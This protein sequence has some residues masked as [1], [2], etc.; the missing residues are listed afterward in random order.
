MVQMRLLLRRLGFFLILIAALVITFALSRFTSSWHYILPVEPGQVAYIAT[1]DHLI[2]DWDQY[3]GLV[4]AQIAD[5]TLRLSAD[6]VQKNPFS[7]TQQHFADFDLRVEA[8]PAE[9]PMNNGYGVVFRVDDKDNNTPTDDSLYRFLISSDGYY[10]VERVIEGDRKWLSAWNPSS[11]VSQGINVT[12]WV[13]VIAEGDRFQFFING[14]QVQVCVPDNPEGE[15]TFSG[16][17]CMGTMQDAIVDNAISS[18]KLG[19]GI[20]TDNEPGVVVEFDN[21]LVYGPETISG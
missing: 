7:A 3:G 8:T 4:E 12:N 18:G 21:F 11:L 13:R 19:V 17:V 9:G 6:D 20:W 5:G 15:S 16:D 1:F 2:E 14:Q 10:A